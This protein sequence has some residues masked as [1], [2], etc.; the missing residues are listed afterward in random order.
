MACRRLIRALREP[1][2]S[3]DTKRK[4]KEA[5][6]RLDDAYEGRIRGR[7]VGDSGKNER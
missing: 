1:G 6:D 3:D 5:L 7:I 2:I 4:L